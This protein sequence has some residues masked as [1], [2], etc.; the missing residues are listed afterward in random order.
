MD[1]KIPRKNKTGRREP[2]YGIF[3]WLINAKQTINVN[4]DRKRVISNT[5][6]CVSFLTNTFIPAKSK[7]AIKIYFTPLD[8][9][10]GVK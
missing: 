7:V 4:M 10:K 1:P 8:I 3:L 5:G 6:R 9:P 2:K